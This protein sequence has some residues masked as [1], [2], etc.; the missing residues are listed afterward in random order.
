MEHFLSHHQI[1]IRALS[2]V[3]IGDGDKIGKKEFIFLRREQRL[4]VPKIEALYAYLQKRGLAARYEQ[5]LFD[6]QDKQKLGDWLRD[7]GVPRKDYEQFTDYELCTE[8]GIFE[9]CGRERPASEILCFIKDAYGKPYVPGSSLKGMMRTALL[10]A[11]VRKNRQSYRTCIEAIRR[12]SS[13]RGKPKSFLKY[14]SAELEDAVF[15]QLMREGT[16]R[17][18]AV[19]DC[20]SGLLVGDSSPIDIERLTLS[21]KIDYNLKQQEQPLPILRECLAPGTVIRFD[22]TIDTQI[23]P[24]TMKDIL[25]ALDLMNKICY[26]FFYSRF[27]T[28]PLRRGTVWLGG[29]CGF[30]SKTVVYPL[31]EE[32]AVRVTD[33]VFQTALGGKY[34]EHKHMRDIGTYRLAPHVCKC[35][36]Y[37]KKLYPMGQGE[38]SLIS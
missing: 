37:Q 25:E 12:E 20:L 28:W 21:Q 30:L 22:V 32:E 33:Q 5:Y 27:F 7:S 31:F 34:I 3:F 24:Y 38:I 1:Q 2:P 9:R 10:A 16:Q 13:R 11:E 29:G 8:E 4:L 14:E 6:R 35:T 26:K 17:S 19:N 36:R 23:C 15:H 18:D